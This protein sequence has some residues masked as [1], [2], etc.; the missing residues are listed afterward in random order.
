MLQRTKK[1]NII[2]LFIMIQPLIRIYRTFWGDNLKV[3]GFSLFEMINTFFI[4]GLWVYVFYKTKNKK[5]LYIFLFFIVLGIY[6]VLHFYNIS[7]FNQSI[8]ERSIYGFVKE[9]YNIFR[10]YGLPILFLFT[11]FFM[12]LRLEFVEKVICDVAVLVSGIIVFSNLTGTSL[13]TYIAEGH[14]RLIHGN[15]FSWFMT[16][17]T[18]N[19]KLYTSS[20]WF[21]SGNEVSGLLFITLP[22]VIYR[23]FYNTTI[24]NIVALAMVMVSMVML[25]TKTATIGSGV[26]MIVML[27][28]YA[29]VGII[30]KNYKATKK[31]G[32]SLIC[33]GCIWG[34]LFYYSPY[35]QEKFPR[36]KQET[37]NFVEQ[38]DIKY[39]VEHKVELSL[40]TEEESEKALEYIKDHYWDHYVM[41]QYVQL[42][43]I[44]GDLEF[45]TTIINRNPELNQNYRNFKQE[46]LDRIIERNDNSLDKW[47]GI[48][49]LH[50]IYCERDYVSEYYMYG[51]IGCILLLGVYVIMLLKYI[52]IFLINGKKYWDNKYISGLCAL[53]V[54]L[55]LPY[56]TGHMFGVPMV[57]FQL[58][59]LILFLKLTRSSIEEEQ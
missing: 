17:G 14:R 34:V 6:C 12:N 32:I 54:G 28:G 59:L 3:F 46:L 21:E 2:Y 19:M 25:G 24:K 51:F 7:Q 36:V 1:E 5:M 39:E 45:W 33:I 58:V 38:D 43:P 47:V 15:I 42:Y 56:V 57:M 48:G 27:A 4:I 30:H 49:L 18:E 11:L 44:E 16:N 40:E 26:L 20:G 9:S 31:A 53:G 55:L 23:F 52:I 22:I 29:L 35:I 50:E 13:C 37:E 10:V 8:M 41:D